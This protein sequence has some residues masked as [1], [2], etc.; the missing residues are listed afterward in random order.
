M[1]HDRLDYFQNHILQVGSTQNR[2][3]MAKTFTTIELFYL[4]IGEHLHE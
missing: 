2:E 4:I 3:A 1:D